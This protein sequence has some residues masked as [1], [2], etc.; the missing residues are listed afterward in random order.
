MPNLNMC[1]A[2]WRVTVNVKSA[3][4]KNNDKDS[5]TNNFK[6]LKN[7]FKECSYLMGPLFPW[8]FRVYNLKQAI[9]MRKGEK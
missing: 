9:Y 1:K 2:K 7:N 5:N 4:Y 6:I 3:F 8:P